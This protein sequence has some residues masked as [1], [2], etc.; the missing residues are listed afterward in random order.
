MFSQKIKSS[1]KSL[2]TISQY[3]RLVRAYL[4][5]LDEYTKKHPTLSVHNNHNVPSKIVNHYLNNYLVDECNKSLS[6]VNQNVTALRAYY[7]WLANFEFCKTAPL[8]VK[9]QFMEPARLNTKRKM[10]LKY[11]SHPLLSEL[12]QCNGII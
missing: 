1:P 9:G 8:F 6:A 12:L 11:F 10:K 2:E 7:D 4:E 3:E 5:W